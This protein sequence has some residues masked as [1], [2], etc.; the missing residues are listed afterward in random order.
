MRSWSLV[1]RVTA[2]VFCAV[3][4]TACEGPNWQKDNAGGSVRIDDWTPIEVS[5]LTGNLPEVL[6]G[7]PLKDAKRALRD[8]AVQHDNVIITDRGFANTQRVIAP[9]SYFGE[10][11]FSQLQSRGAF[12]AWVRAR[13]PQA[14]QVEFADMIPVIHP[15]ITTRGF[16]ATV[17]VTDQHDRRFRCAMTYTGYGGP[18]LSAT[19]TDIF[20]MEELK[21][22]LQ[23]MLCTTNAS[24][25]WLHQRMQRAAF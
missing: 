23:I 14:K 17:M 24:A 13:L 22:T 3:L 2:L 4:V 21:S 7:L 10:Q 12:E 8:N 19:N 20:R 25:A 11:M 18:R 16:V 9:N 6:A 1:A 15:S 5:Q